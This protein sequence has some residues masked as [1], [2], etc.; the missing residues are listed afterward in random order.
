MT[1]SNFSAQFFLNPSKFVQFFSCVKKFHGSLCL[2]RRGILNLFTEFL[3]YKS[4]ISSGR[5]SHLNIRNSSIM[6]CKGFSFLEAP[7]LA[8]FH[9][10]CMELL[11]TGT[12]V[13]FRGVASISSFARRPLIYS[14]ALPF[15]L[16]Q[17]PA[18]WY[19]LLLRIAPSETENVQ[20]FRFSF[21][22]TNRLANMTVLIRAQVVN[23]IW[24][25]NNLHRKCQNPPKKRTLVEDYFGEVTY[26]P[27]KAYDYS[28]QKI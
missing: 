20:F 13:L 27:L 5:S 18:M 16:R 21:F 23:N 15:D 11:G 9:C 7:R 8:H 26:N 24:H 6:P 4:M 3:L 2:G 12:A 14:R 10:A 25:Y 1:N 17:L 28:L 22:V 19:Q